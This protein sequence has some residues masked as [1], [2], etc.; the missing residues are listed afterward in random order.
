MFYD[1]NDKTSGRTLTELCH[2]IDKQRMLKVLL[3]LFSFC[4]LLLSE[5]LN[6]YKVCFVF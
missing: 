2:Q 4:R 6:F 5:V 3:I 1:D